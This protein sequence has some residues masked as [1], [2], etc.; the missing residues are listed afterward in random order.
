M[1][2]RVTAALAALAAALLAA[3][4]SD[5]ATE[6]SPAPGPGPGPG[7]V[8][9]HSVQITPNAPALTVGQTLQLTAT[10]ADATGKPITGRTV[11]WTSS[12][13]QYVTVSGTGLLT[14]VA[15]GTAKITAT[16]EGKSAQITVTVTQPDV[17]VASVEITTALDT[18]E[19]YDVVPLA[20]VVR[21]ED[22]QVLNGRQVTWTSSNPAVASVNATTGVLT[23]HDRG[24]VTITATSE[25]VSGTATRVVVIKYRS[26]TA[27]T[28][29]ACDIA[30]GGI[31]WC[32]G[33]NGAEG[34]IGDPNMG[35][36]AYRAVPYR[37][38][39]TIRFKMLSTSGRHTCGV[40]TDNRAYCWGYNG[41]GGLG[42]GT[43]IPSSP[44][45]I[46]VAG[47]I[48]F[49]SV[50]AGA[51]HSCGIS[52][53]DKAYCWG[54]ADWRQ[55]GDGSSGY[56]LSPVAVALNES[57]KAIEAG[58]GFTC[59]ITMA[60]AAYCWGANS[61]GQIGDGQ[62]ISYGNTFVAQPTKVA[63]ALSFA[64]ID[65]SNQYTCA[66]TPTGS[67][68]CW[69]RDGGRFGRGAGNDSSSPVAAATGLSLRS[70]ST[71]NDHA[72]GVAQDFG[73]WCW[74]SNDN[75]RLGVPLPNGSTTPVRVAGNLSGQEVAA[76]G[77]AT[78]SAAH[79]CAISVDRLTVLCWGRNDVG[80]L[81]NGSTSDATASNA[82]PVIVVGQKP[83]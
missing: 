38:S 62:P 73:I 23:G 58:P 7:P 54:H 72:C 81:G 68:Y 20:A 83:L 28:M 15:A 9:V 79:T 17:A 42:S 69:G 39:E 64:S 27:G 22:N 25:G 46:P 1:T 59:A 41:W 74:G 71:G 19:A 16:A 45:P 43:N 52:T 56:T 31:A 8:P 24:T 53:A 30:S 40:A 55:L 18:L 14:G 5:S 57:V 70:I 48:L 78:G 82:T 76:A 35:S 34:R 60:G 49:K 11:T 51:D 32:W 80:Q 10:L 3:C 2:R 63:T 65:V 21:D 33:L 4:G 37:V 29:H 66:T 75:G 61:I 67:A 50:T 77:I 36:N 26:I 6:P 12:A 44:T 47:G 13:Q